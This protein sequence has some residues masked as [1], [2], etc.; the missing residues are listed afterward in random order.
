MHFA[1]IVKLLR[2]NEILGEKLVIQILI[3][4]Y[5]GKQPHGYE[6]YL[7]MKLLSLWLCRNTFIEILYL[8]IH[9]Y[10]FHIKNMIVFYIKIFIVNKI[11]LLCIKYIYCV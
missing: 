9:V 7:N 10:V 6:L 4:P 2:G 1:L 3:D 5:Q 11:Y 8:V